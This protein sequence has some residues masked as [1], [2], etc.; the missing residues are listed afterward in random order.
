MFNGIKAKYESLKAYQDKRKKASFMSM[1]EKTAALKEE[2]KISAN[3]EREKKKQYN[4]KKSIRNRKLEP[5]RKIAKDIRSNKKRR[6][7]APMFQSEGGARNIFDNDR[8]GGVFDIGKSK[9]KKE[10]KGKSIIIKIN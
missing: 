9:P 2:N 1:K 7:A 4:I 8:S 10:K 5:M 6:S 3:L